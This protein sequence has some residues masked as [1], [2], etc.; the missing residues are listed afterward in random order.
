M[1]SPPAQVALVSSAQ[2]IT[3]AVLAYGAALQGAY[4]TAAGRPPAQED[5]LSHKLS[6]WTDNGAYYDCN[7]W[8]A[9]APGKPTANDV[10]ANLTAW[11]AQAGFPFASYQVRHLTTGVPRLRPLHPRC[12][13][14][15]VQVDPW[16]YVGTDAPAGCGL[17]T[18]WSANPNIW[19]EG[20][21][22]TGVPL[23]LYSSYYAPLSEG[24]VMTAYTWTDSVFINIGWF[25][26][27]LSQARSMIGVRVGVRQ[28]AA[29]ANPPVQVVASDAE[30]F[31]TDI[32]T[33][34]LA[35]GMDAFEVRPRSG[36][37]ALQRVLTLRDCLFCCRWISSTSR[38][39]PS[40]TASTTR[41]RTRTGCAACTSR[42]PPR[43]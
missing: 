36:M 28:G 15:A 8:G 30:A 19:P 6:Y 37:G 24:N 43:T 3:D 31:F 10:F 12:L 25:V 41:R 21:A 11:H 27:K 22:A 42:P 29:A 39:S 32:M 14:A 16:W 2:G 26:G 35:W 20:L 34:G 1:N 40:L 7:W 5:V 18:N 33:K 23:T 38:T 9:W 4:K 17:P 13:L